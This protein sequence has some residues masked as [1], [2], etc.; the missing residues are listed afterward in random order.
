M[1]PE[2]VQERVCVCVWG[3]AQNSVQNGTSR[4]CVLG[5]TS[6]RTPLYR[7]V[8]KLSTSHVKTQKLGTSWPSHG[9]PRVPSQD[10]KAL[11]F[12]IARRQGT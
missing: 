8:R 1:V 5:G 11:T 9:V 12:R 2:M 3:K 6:L 7:G 10:T 4:M